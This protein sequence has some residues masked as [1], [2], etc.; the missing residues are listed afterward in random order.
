MSLQVFD[1][2]R[3]AI[4]QGVNLLVEYR[5]KIRNNLLTMRQQAVSQSETVQF[6][7]DRVNGQAVLLLDKV[8]KIE[9]AIADATRRGRLVDGLTRIGITQA[10]AVA[11]KNQLKTAGEALQ[12]ASKGNYAQ[13]IAAIDA[14]LTSAPAPDS[15]WPE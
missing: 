14:F 7:A 4:F 13:I 6:L 1:N 10:E 8:T 5:W 15:F 2:V 3:L 12:S 11:A 9:A